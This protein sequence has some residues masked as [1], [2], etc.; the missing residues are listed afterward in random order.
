MARVKKQN[1]KMLVRTVLNTGKNVLNLECRL[2]QLLCEIVGQ[3]LV[4]L[5]I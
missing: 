5:N 3:F 1:V 2:A 4:K